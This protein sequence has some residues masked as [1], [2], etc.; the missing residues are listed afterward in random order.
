[1]YVQ[2]AITSPLCAEGHHI[3][4]MC[5]RPC[6]SIGGAQLAAYHSS[7][8]SLSVVLHTWLMQKA[9]SG[10][11]PVG[12]G[13]LPRPSLLPINY[14]QGLALGQ[15][16]FWGLHA[17][18]MQEAKSGAV[19]EGPSLLPRARPASHQPPVGLGKKGYA[20]GQKGF[21]GLV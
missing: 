11:V 21:K 18:F 16:A 13:P 5:R 8:R 4:A 10:A 1:M 12:L 19:P 3:T 7:P 14:L 2:K 15:G 9:N 6:S 17:R 20:F